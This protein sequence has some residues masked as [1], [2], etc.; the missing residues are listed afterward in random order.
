M[1]GWKAK[2]EELWKALQE[3]AQGLDV[4]Q[5]KPFLVSMI[6][7]QKMASYL[8]VK[9]CSNGMV[10]AIKVDGLPFNPDFAELITNC[11]SK[12]AQK[13]KEKDIQR[14]LNE[15]K[16]WNKNL[17]KRTRVVQDIVLWHNN[18]SI[19]TTYVIQ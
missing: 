9:K 10:D 7:I 16:D 13:N 11:K 18:L 4:A 15:E 19:M 1:K 8:G 17:K 3:K 5:E 12:F 2:G 6:G 14:L